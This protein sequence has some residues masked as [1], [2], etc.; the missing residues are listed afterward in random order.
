FSRLVQCRTGHAF[1]GQYYERFVPDESAT[2][3]CGERLETRTHILQ[4]CP[5]YDDW[6]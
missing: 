2:C 1:I 6:R 4:D 5:L 3:C